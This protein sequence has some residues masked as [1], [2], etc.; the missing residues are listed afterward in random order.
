MENLKQALGKQ[1]NKFDHLPFPLPLREIQY[2]YIPASEKIAKRDLSQ[3]NYRP[4]Y[5]KTDVLRWQ[6]AFSLRPQLPVTVA[7]FCL[8]RN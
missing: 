7:Y 4:A 3:E 2:L 8:R 6:S 5:Y 1:A